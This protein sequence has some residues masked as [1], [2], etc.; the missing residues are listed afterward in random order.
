[1]LIPLRLA[2][3]VVR[4]AARAVV[5]ALVAI[6]VG[7][8]LAARRITGDRHAGAI[9][10]AGAAPAR[11]AI[12]VLGFPT[13]RSGAPHPVQRWRVAMACRTWRATGARRV[14]FCGG[15]VRSHHV[16]ADDMA[17][18]ARSAGM[19]PDV[20]VCER[21]SR[22]TR[23]NVEH[24]HGLV[25]GFDT[26]LLVSDPFHA[27]RARTRWLELF[28]ADV[29][30]VAYGDIQRPFEKLWL[31]AASAVFEVIL[32]VRRSIGRRVHP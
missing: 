10:T 4:T 22:T 29:A 3:F 7:T 16:E 14:V 27:R 8:E 12:V 25:D 23:E 26:V 32:R 2:R 20:I 17:Q 5:V 15:A 28:P 13:R 18:L 19:P 11:T 21:E 9:G 31:K 30:R 24:A 6:V 1:M